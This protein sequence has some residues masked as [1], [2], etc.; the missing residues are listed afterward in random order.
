MNTITTNSNTNIN[1]K[2]IAKRHMDLMNSELTGDNKEYTSSIYNSDYNKSDFN[3]IESS[4]NLI[5]IVLNFKHDKIPN[6]FT[7][8]LTIGV[9]MLDLYD[10]FYKNWKEFR[11]DKNE[12]YWYNQT[13][14]KSTWENPL[15]ILF[16]LMDNKI[17]KKMSPLY[18]KSIDDR[19]IKIKFKTGKSLY[20]DKKLKVIILCNMI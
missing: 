17:D 10:G 12:L 9:E 14:N 13:V 19:I 20:I 2:E 6:I 1:Y 11:T 3:N 5:Q 15:G 7:T 8:R 16:C 4:T 18:W